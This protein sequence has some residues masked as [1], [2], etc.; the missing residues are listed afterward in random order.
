MHVAWTVSILNYRFFLITEKDYSYV[1]IWPSPGGAGCSHGMDIARC[2]YRGHN[3][4][5][6]GPVHRHAQ[7]AQAVG[8]VTLAPHVQKRIRN[9]HASTF[10]L[11]LSSKRTLQK[12]F[13]PLSMSKGS[14]KTF[15]CH[16]VHDSGTFCA[17][18]ERCLRQLWDLQ[19]SKPP[20][21]QRTT[22]S[23][24]PFSQLAKMA[25]PACSLG[26]RWLVSALVCKVLG[27]LLQGFYGH[28]WW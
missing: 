7:Q 9:V 6:W 15:P 20:Q 21:N 8:A 10:L 28:P 19:L 23:A 18:S 1:Y 25:V 5:A 14:S 13:L 12:F 4:P 22:T 26:W 11:H 3:E 24:R 27:H 16:S 17:L 2:I